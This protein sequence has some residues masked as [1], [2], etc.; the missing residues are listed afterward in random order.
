MIEKTIFKV[1]QVKPMLTVNQA[2]SLILDIIS[3]LDQ[4]EICPLKNVFNRVLAESVSSDL[5][6]P[7]W[8]NSAMDGYAV[9][10]EDV[11]RATPAQPIVLTVIEEIPAGRKPQLTLRS[12]QAARIFTGAMLPAGADTVVMQENTQAQG[13]RVSILIAPS[14]PQMF[15]RKKGEYAE[16]GKILLAKGTTIREP[17]MAI[18]ATAQKTEVTVYRRPLVAI[19]STG[20]E[21]ISPDQTLEP[22]QIIDSNQFALASFLQ[23]QGA[24]TLNLGIVA[25]NRDR[26]RETM[27]QAI[28]E[29]DLVLSTG[30]VS[31]GDYDYVEELLKELGGE[32]L[33][34]SVAIKPGK[35]LTVAK[36]AN[37]CIYFGIPGNPVSALVSCWR[38]VQ[39]ALKKL[40]GLTHPW[41]PSFIKARTNNSLK[42]D[43]KRETY[44]WGKVNWDDLGN[45]Q[46]QVASG[47]HSSGN[48]INL[49]QTNCLA[50]LPPREQIIDIEQA[51]LVMLIG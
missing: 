5:D 38:F 30:G 33:I 11:Q 28:N 25:D 12:Q 45:A 6:F 27:S 19:F 34:Q 13:D 8:D 31:V 42:P 1:K 51:I 9:K 26:L 48:L 4:T 16:A 22:G 3:P 37:G 46:F 2:E 15:V 47:S 10:F 49:A 43:S 41:R 44:L 23:G 18:L 20:D 39:P 24:M 14:N 29:A 7:Y 17:E 36:F 35:P 21:L 40:S 50:Y 32:I